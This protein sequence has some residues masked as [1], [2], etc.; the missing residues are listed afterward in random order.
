KPATI[1][2]R[3][4]MTR[5]KISEELVFK[6][7][8]MA[9][10][11]LRPKIKNVSINPSAS[12]DVPATVQNELLPVK[13]K[14]D[15]NEMCIAMNRSSNMIIPMITSVSGLAVRFKS[16]RTLATMAVEELVIIPH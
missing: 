5:M 9:G 4:K 12:N 2:K 16:V 6:S 15:K 11:N 14:P 10:T 8:S 3:A 7:L 13:I 1:N